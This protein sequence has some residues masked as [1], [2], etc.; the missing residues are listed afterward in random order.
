MRY[1]RAERRFSVVWRRAACAA[2]LLLWLA[3]DP[4]RSAFA[5][6][7]GGLVAGH[8]ARF[9]AVQ[10]L[11]L[12]VERVTT[13]RGKTETDRWT[14]YQKGAQR[15]RIDCEFPLRRVVVANPVELWEYVPEARKAVRTDLGALSQEERRAALRNV[16]RRVALE[17]LRFEPDA[18]GA[19][20]RYVGLEQVDRRP[21]HCIEFR[22][23]EAREAGSV[24][25]WIDAERG[26]LLRCERRD[27][28]GQVLAETVAS[29]V[30]EAAPGFWFPRTL[31][32]REMSARGHSQ[33]LS[34]RRVVVNGEMA[35]E[36]F[37]FQVPEGTEV[38]K[39]G[40]AR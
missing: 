18:A 40:E 38:E 30:F 4:C 9:D 21:A 32:V 22:R 2:F 15:F 7:A 39:G 14:F 35:D 20:L 36:L 6:D 13:R 24:R 37:T 10:S 11:L 28:S 23:K 26:V 16:L 12:R 25:G 31:T 8:L 17:G 1:R 34:F 19:E 33:T 27:K 29:E 3:G 5:G